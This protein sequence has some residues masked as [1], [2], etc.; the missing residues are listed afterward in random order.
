MSKKNHKS[1]VDKYQKRKE[2]IL[3]EI[4][5]ADAPDPERRKE[6]LKASL[7]RLKEYSENIKRDK[8]DPKW[9]AD[10]NGKM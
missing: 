5:L 2:N 3:F 6:Y 9:E 4:D 8:S 10:N 7:Q 1:R